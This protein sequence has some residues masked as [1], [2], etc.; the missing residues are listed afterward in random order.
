MTGS[1]LEEQEL[2]IV[3][4]GIPLESQESR[5]LLPVDSSVQIIFDYLLLGAHYTFL[6]HNLDFLNLIKFYDFR[7]FIYINR[8]Q[9]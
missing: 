7:D 1:V 4:V 6:Q 3:L 5:I 8:P 9:L 2:L